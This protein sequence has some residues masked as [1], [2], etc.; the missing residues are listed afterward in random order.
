MNS[1]QI[2]PWGIAYVAV[3][4][5]FAVAS[6]VAADHLSS[7]EPPSVITR[8][9]VATV[10]GALWPVMLVGIAQVWLIRT[11]FTMARPAQPRPVKPGPARKHRLAP[12]A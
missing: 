7:G 12:A 3:V 6:L 1:I 9:W 4:V 5:L 2:F 8:G 10:A 11:L